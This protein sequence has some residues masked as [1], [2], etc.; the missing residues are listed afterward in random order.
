MSQVSNRS[1]LIAG[2]KLM[3]GMVCS[4]EKEIQKSQLAKGANAVINQDF[5]LAV[6]DSAAAQLEILIWFVP[7]D[8]TW[9][10]MLW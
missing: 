1:I 6:K 7:S 5:K 2:L 8:L 4:P 9:K 10:G 3:S